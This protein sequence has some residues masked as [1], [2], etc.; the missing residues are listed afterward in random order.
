MRARGFEPHGCWPPE[1]SVSTE[2]VGLYGDAGIRWLV[3]DEGILERS[4]GRAL[5]QGVVTS[6]DL[7]RPWRLEGGG[8]VLFFR[9]RWLSDEIGFKCGHW[10]DERRAAAHLVEHLTGLARALPADATVVVALDGENPWLHYPEGGAAFL[11]EL[12]GRLGED[13][14]GLEPVTLSQAVERRE[15]ATLPT[16]HP[17]SWINGN[18]STWIGHPEK[19][20]AWG[21]LAAVRAAVGEERAAQCPSLLTAEASDWFWWLGDDNPTPLA[22][23]YDRIFRRHLQDLCHQAGVEPPVDL[24]R[25]LK[26]VTRPMA[27]PVSRVWPA[28]VLDGL[29]TSYFEWSLAAW[30]SAEVEQ[31]LRRLALRAD[32]DEL[33]L[34]V[35]GRGRMGELLADQPLSVVLQSP[36]GSRL[37]LEV[38][39]SGCDH[40]RVRCGVDRVMEMSIPWHG[41]GGYRLEVRLGDCSLP[42]GAALLVEPLEVDEELPA[43]GAG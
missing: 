43:A 22:P 7:Y 4:L 27:V 35:E 28:P 40:P 24:D 31:P 23:L 41:Q 25:P 14:L 17:G 19:T 3:T 15:P 30:V 9:D 5:R 6:S 37:E 11:A 10:E 36:E 34:L 16:L 12:L 13:G 33:H 39:P 38:S 42:E 29:V 2:A 8:P 18:F 21:V 1:G 20:A 32:G 26:A